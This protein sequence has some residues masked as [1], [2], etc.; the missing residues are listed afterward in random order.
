MYINL[1][2]EA[3]LTASDIKSTTTADSLYV[4]STQLYG[5]RFPQQIHLPI[6]I[7]AQQQ[8]KGC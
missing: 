8:V 7:A 4:K 3:Q 2:P 6:N 5:K 1:L